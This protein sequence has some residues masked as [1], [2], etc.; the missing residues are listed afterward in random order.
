MSNI[1]SAVV[2]TLAFLIIAPSALSQPR[3]PPSLTDPR[4]NSPAT[5][6]TT[7]RPTVPDRDPSAQRPD[8]FSKSCEDQLREARQLVSNQKER[9]DLLEVIRK[10][11][12]KDNARLKSNVASLEAEVA[13]LKRQLSSKR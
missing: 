12:E 5:S 8:S 13:A 10:D 2:T 4:P 11:L 9:I 6:P 3:L 1:K 7:T